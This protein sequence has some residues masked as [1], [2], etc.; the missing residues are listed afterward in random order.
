MDPGGRN[1]GGLSNQP[2]AEKFSAALIRLAG[3]G[4]GG[5]DFKTMLEN[6]SN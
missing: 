3:L 6:F 5:K 1:K 2:V 4:D